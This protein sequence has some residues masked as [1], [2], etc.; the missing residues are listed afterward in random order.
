MKAKLATCIGVLSLAAAGAVGAVMYQKKIALAPSRPAPASILAGDKAADTDRHRSPGN[1]LEDRASAAAEKAAETLQAILGNQSVQRTDPTDRSPAFD[2]ARIEPTGD[3]VIAGRAA[4]GATVEL[5]RG[6]EVHDQALA[7]EAGEFVLV[8]R[9]LPPGNYDLTLRSTQSDGQKLTSKGSV[10]VALAPRKDERRAVAPVG[11]RK[12]E[13]P[14]VAQIGPRKDDPLAVATPGSRKDDR[15]VVAQVGPGKDERPAVAAIAPRKDDEPVVASVVP[16][17]PVL[18]PAKPVVA[19]VGSIAIDTV[20]SKPDGKLY[21]SGRSAAD[22]AVRLF[23][24]DAYIASATPSAEGRV[25]FAI[26]SGVTPGDYRVRLEKVDASGSVQSRAESSLKVPATFA[27]AS[28]RS[29]PASRPESQARPPLGTEP[30]ASTSDVT[31]NTP[32]RADE[33]ALP[34]PAA[35]E[36]TENK[37][38]RADQAALPRPAGASGATENRPPRPDE[39]TSSRPAGPPEVVADRTPRAQEPALLP[40]TGPAE[41]TENT[42][43][44][45]QEPA[46]LPSPATPDIKSQTAAAVAPGDEVGVVVVPKIETAVVARGDNLWRISRTTYGRGVRYPIIF[47]ANRD[48]IRNP[49]L[50]YPGQVFVLPN[51]PDDEAHARGRPLPQ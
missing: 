40:P 8:P 7:N 27:T 12:D 34:R 20:D 10:A 24:N 38:A 25:A 6:G 17:K 50:I 11:P 2:V 18:A 29:T 45:A 46:L 35:S 30:T 13:R 26:E 44:R 51:A 36:T 49:D 5:L 21:V 41:V 14:A 22:G 15:P 47:D 23:L 37:L 39:P 1:S 48:Q 4:P 42:T 43:P 16:D 19:E 9:P 33:P 31:A 28:A 3:A 32:P